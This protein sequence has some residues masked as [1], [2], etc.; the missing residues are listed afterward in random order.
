MGRDGDLVFI[1]GRS[2]LGVSFYDDVLT[3]KYLLKT[4]EEKC[5]KA[6]ELTWNHR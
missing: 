5:V 3:L 6:K 2:A 1:D 4:E